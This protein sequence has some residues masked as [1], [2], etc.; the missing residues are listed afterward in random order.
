MGGRLVGAPCM[1]VS[2]DERWWQGQP[3]LDVT[4]SGTE[5][6][7]VPWAAGA[8]RTEH[9]GER[10]G[11][12]DESA[13]EQG[14]GDQ[15][16]EGDRDSAEHNDKEPARTTSPSNPEINV[17]VSVMSLSWRITRN[18]HFIKKQ[19]NI[20]ALGKAVLL[21]PRWVGGMDSGNAFANGRGPRA[22]RT[23]GAVAAWSETCPPGWAAGLCQGDGGQSS[24]CRGRYLWAHL[25][26]WAVSMP[27]LHG[28][29]VFLHEGLRKERW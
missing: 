16:E 18:S 12:A 22:A 24:Q 25:E 21:V 17:R 2:V 20:K 15:R 19:T 10:T 27:H 28:Y 3:E 1:C 9:P 11:K 4:V 23:K 6:R 7:R 8:C 13:Q 29:S 5:I 26:P 14:F